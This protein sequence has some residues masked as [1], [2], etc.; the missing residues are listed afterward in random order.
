MSTYHRVPYSCKQF[1]IAGTKVVIPEM[2][3]NTL[4]HKALHDKINNNM[5]LFGKFE[6]QLRLLRT[7]KNRGVMKALFFA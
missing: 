1:S 6:I 3:E 7:G 4:Q 5:I 2:L